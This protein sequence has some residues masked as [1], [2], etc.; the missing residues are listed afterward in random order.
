MRLVPIFLA[1]WAPLAAV[2]GSDPQAES[3]A[4]IY[5]SVCLKHLDNLDV[6]A[7][8]LSAVPALPADKASK[9]LNGA[10]GRAWPVP[11]KHGTFVVAIPSGRNVCSV[12]AQRL[13]ADSANALFVQLVQAA[14]PPLKAR[15]LRDDVQPHRSGIRRS[16]AYEWF[17]DGKQKRLQFLLTT[18]TAAD[19]DVQGLA[20][21]SAGQ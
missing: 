9:F 5:A 3:F 13:S 21:A 11:D 14:P 10:P 19:A 6:V 18:S 4:N 12:Y 20:T 1:F 2:A 7:Q 17:V 8:K 15:R 16:V